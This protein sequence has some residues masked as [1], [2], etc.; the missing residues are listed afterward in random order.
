MKN[1]LEEISDLPIKDCNSGITY[2]LSETPIFLLE[3]IFNTIDWTS[4]EN[5]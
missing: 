3:K 1:W 2:K 5:V 4:A